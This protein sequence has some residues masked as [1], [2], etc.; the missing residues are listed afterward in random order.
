M[1]A[2]LRRWVAGDQSV[3]VLLIVDALIV[4]VLLSWETWI[5]DAPRFVVP[6]LWGPLFGAAGL[7]AATYH[8]RRSSPTLWKLSGVLLLT[9][10]LL[11]STAIALSVDEWTVATTILTLRWLVFAGVVWHVWQK[12]VLPR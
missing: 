6:W 1:A 2:Y 7:T 4:A 3:L 10:Y 9:A 8:Q 12:V 11:R 5:T